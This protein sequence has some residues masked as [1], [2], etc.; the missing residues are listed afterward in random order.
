VELLPKQP[1]DTLALSET[2]CHLLLL[3]L[4]LLVV[5]VVVAV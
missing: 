1:P 4:L 2:R 5:V 3:L